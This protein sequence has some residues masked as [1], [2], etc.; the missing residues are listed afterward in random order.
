MAVEVILVGV[1]AFA[2]GALVGALMQR[3]A[4][5]WYAPSQVESNVV[6]VDLDELAFLEVELHNMHEQLY[7]I[8]NTVADLGVNG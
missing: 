7:E 6:V 1:G 5:D 8:R 2:L 4:Y 3:W